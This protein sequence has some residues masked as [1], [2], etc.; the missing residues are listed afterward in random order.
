M[1]SHCTVLIFRYWKKKKKYFKKINWTV[2]NRC[3]WGF[4]STFVC[5]VEKTTLFNSNTVIFASIFWFVCMQ[6]FLYLNLSCRFYMTVVTRIGWTCF[7]LF[8]SSKFVPIS[9]K[10]TDYLKGTSYH[11]C[12]CQVYK[13]HKYISV[14]HMQVVIWRLDI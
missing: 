5:A 3:S 6:K 9:I 14:K 13:K 2:G 7:Y 11:T 8:Q 4:S 1:S 12:T 10:F